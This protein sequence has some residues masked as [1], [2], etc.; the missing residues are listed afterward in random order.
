MP[1]R[2]DD[3]T[4]SAAHS[5]SSLSSSRRR[6]LRSSWCATVRAPPATVTV[7]TYRKLTVKRIVTLAL[8]L[9]LPRTL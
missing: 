5:S 2:K 6:A 8:T 7:Q 1:A 9:P 3:P 4:A